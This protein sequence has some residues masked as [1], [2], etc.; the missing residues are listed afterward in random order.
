MLPPGGVPGGFRQV[1]TVESVGSGGGVLSGSWNRVHN[2]IELP[3][4]SQPGRE[5][6]VVTTPDLR[7]ITPSTYRDVPPR[8]EGHR[9]LYAVGV[10]LQSGG[11]PVVDR[12]FVTLRL[13]GKEFTR[14]DFVLFFSTTRHGFVPAPKGHARCVNGHVVVRFRAG[15]ELLV[16]GG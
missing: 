2:T 1:E 11:R 13:A 15:T 10:L 3:P 4:G 14:A 8:L 16:L 12:R 7:T 6:V 9:P 5:L